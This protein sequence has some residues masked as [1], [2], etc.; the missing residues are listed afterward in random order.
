MTIV[1]GGAPSAPAT[2]R[3]SVYLPAIS[4]PDPEVAYIWGNEAYIRLYDHGTV[5][6][7]RGALAPSG[8]ERIVGLV[9]G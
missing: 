2:T 9:G 7:K 1:L 6:N 5:Y 4:S 8:L 3:G